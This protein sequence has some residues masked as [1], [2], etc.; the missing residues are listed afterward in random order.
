M[1]NINLN[2]INDK[3][4]KVSKDLNIEKV[5]VVSKELVEQEL[6]I[7]I[8]KVGFKDPSKPEILVDCSYQGYITVLSKS[9]LF[10]LETVQISTHQDNRG[11]IIA[12]KGVLSTGSLTIRR[13][14]RKVMTL[15]DIES[16]RARARHMRLKNPRVIDKTK[17]AQKCQK[18]ELR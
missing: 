1:I 6:H 10:S 2:E 4:W 14:T 9:E 11:Y 16:L 18:K 7:N 3:S 17:E 8:C 5:R 13:K 15:S 12:V